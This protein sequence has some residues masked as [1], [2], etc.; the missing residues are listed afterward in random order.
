MKQKNPERRSLLP[1]V[2]LNFVENDRSKTNFITFYFITPLNEKSASCNTLLSRLLTREC[3]KYPRQIALCRALDDCYEANLSSDSMKIGEWHALS[4][5]LSLLDNAY[6][7]EG[8]DVTARGLS[9]LEEVLF[10]P[11]LKDGAFPEESVKG[12]K[13]QALQEID[14]LVNRK[15]L[16]ARERMVEVMC[17][18]EPYGVCAL[19]T[20]R[21]VARETAASLGA[22]YRDLLRA[23]QIEIFFVGRFDREK[24]GRRMEKLFAGKERAFSPLPPLAE[25][26]EKEMAL[27]VTERLD[28]TQTHLVMGFRTHCTTSSP[29]WRAFTV[30]NAI[31]GGLPTSKLFS[32][33]R[34]KM[35]LCYTVFSSPDGKKGVMTVYAGIDGKNRDKAIRE[36]KRLLEAVKA[37]DFSE[38]ELE[39][40]RLALISRVRG[41]EDQPGILSDFYLFRFLAG[42]DGAPAQIIR[43]LEQV[44]RED[45]VRAARG[46]TLDTIYT[47][48]GKEG[49]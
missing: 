8:E 5:E 18:K 13:K 28:V 11:A 15:A 22:Y 43:E 37:G 38:E 47:L 33:L 44:T 42:E 6:A 26:A 17:R 27:E 40:A 30:F 46:V 16:Y 31:L 14:S 9:I 45:V 7:L 4:V 19:G 32:I 20:K 25:A 3:E 35:S 23:S 49:V 21:G 1:G 29:S 39:N 41:Y 34:E 10:R 12:E 48:T 36:V 24:I 2:T